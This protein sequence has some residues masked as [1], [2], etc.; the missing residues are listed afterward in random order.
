MD[1]VIR[2]AEKLDDFTK[3]KKFG[4]LPGQQI[5]YGGG[6]GIKLLTHHR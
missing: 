1:K 5:A 2:D 4:L 3:T 6:F